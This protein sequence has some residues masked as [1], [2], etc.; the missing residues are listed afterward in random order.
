MAEVIKFKVFLTRDSVDRERK[1]EIRRFVMDPVVV[2]NYTYLCEKLQTIFPELR[3]RRFSVT[4]KDSED[5]DIMISS[6]E[7]LQIALTE[8]KNDPIHK[9]YV[10][11]H[12][13]Y[14]D[15]KPAFQADS[16]TTY[17]V[18]A[19]KE[20]HVGIV[21]DGCDKDIFGFGYKCLRCVD[22]DLCTEC[23]AKGSHPEH[24]MIR[25]PTPQQRKL[26]KGKCL[27][28]PIDVKVVTGSTEE[29]CKK[30]SHKHR[31]HSGGQ[32]YHHNQVP[33]WLNTLTTYL[34]D[35]AY[36][37]EEC[38]AA[39]EFKKQKNNK[40]S[41]YSPHPSTS[42]NLSPSTEEKPAEIRVKAEPKP[43]EK[44][45][46]TKEVAAIGQP[47]VVNL[48]DVKQETVNNNTNVVANSNPTAPHEENTLHSMQH[49]QSTQEG[50]ATF[51]AYECASTS[52]NPKDDWTLLDKSDIPVFNVAATNATSN[53]TIQETPEALSMYPSLPTIFD[54][55]WHS[56]PKIQ[57]AV[58]AMIQM[59]FTNEGG[60]LTQLLVLKNGDIGKVLDILQPVNPKNK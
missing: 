7:E 23:E 48:S 14:E 8:M 32:S 1:P 33:S 29:D 16:G 6:C 30:H 53:A 17:T 20:K 28:R 3:G 2:T 49:N 26:H 15:A 10:A 4:W 11:L 58:D 60:W 5:D 47:G 24:C 36:L 55:V 19:N 41:G 54:S 52:V 42:S 18:P 57:S 59:G 21:C 35:W 31:R 40:S 25:F 38:P 46:A 9:L 45:V 43:Q 34:N 44:F 51:T 27:F 12:S 37:P 22:Y 39:E 56:D 13:E 50:L